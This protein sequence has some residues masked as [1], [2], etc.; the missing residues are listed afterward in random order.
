M[1]Q[2]R[3]AKAERSIT[4]TARK[5][6]D[7]TSTEHSMSPA[8]ILGDLRASG[9]N[10]QINMVEGCLNSL[11]SD[12]LV[13]QPAPGLYMRVTAKPRIAKVNPAP[14]GEPD[15]DVTPDSPKHPEFEAAREET[16]VKLAQ[17]SSRTRSMSK[18]LLQMSGDLAAISDSIDDVAL[19]VEER[20]QNIQRDTEKLRQLQSL[21]KQLT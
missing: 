9:V 19:D 20:I 13:R 6:L 2:A 11:L 4:T 14:S 17:V 18:A 5:V 16:L 15:I 1:N 10:I 21:L 12:G 8:K 7:A 3:L